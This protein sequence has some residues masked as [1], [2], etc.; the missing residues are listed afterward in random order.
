M[1]KYIHFGSE[2]GALMNFSN[3]TQYHGKM[4]GGSE[5]L[6]DQMTSSDLDEITGN[7]R[8]SKW[9]GNLTADQAYQVMSDSGI[10]LSKYEKLSLMS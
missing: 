7:T 1:G 2:N 8:N 3:S 5:W 9:F 6:A 4:A 10:D